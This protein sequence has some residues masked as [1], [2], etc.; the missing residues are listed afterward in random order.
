MQ[1][2]QNTSMMF[3]IGLL[4]IQGSTAAFSIAF[5][6]K[7]LYSFGS[8]SSMF[9]ILNKYN[10]K[11]TPPVFFIIMDI[12]LSLFTFVFFGIEKAFLLLINATAFFIVFN[13]SLKFLDNYIKN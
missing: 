12:L 3:N 8:Y 6:M 13:Y 2:F 5:V 11:V 1:Q 9:P 4:I 7:H 10:K